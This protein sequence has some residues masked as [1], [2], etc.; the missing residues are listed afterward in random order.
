MYFLNT[1]LSILPFVNTNVSPLH[2]K[3]IPKHQKL[4]ENTNEDSIF[5]Q[6]NTANQFPK[7]PEYV[8]VFN[9]LFSM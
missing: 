8:N 1:D 5:Y 6:Y 2:K 4:N 3:P 9:K 7:T